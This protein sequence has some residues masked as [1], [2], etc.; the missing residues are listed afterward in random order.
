VAG[1]LDI[2]L[3][4]GVRFP[5]VP[6]IVPVQVMTFLSSGVCSHSCCLRSKRWPLIMLSILF[7]GEISI[8]AVCMF[9]IMDNL[10][11]TPQTYRQ[12]F[13]LSVTCAREI[14]PWIQHCKFELYTRLWT[15]RLTNILDVNRELNDPLFTW[16]ELIENQLTL[17]IFST[18]PLK[19][20]WFLYM[21]KDYR[22]I[23]LLS[24]SHTQSLMDVLL[25]QGIDFQYF[26][27]G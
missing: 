25:Q 27:W 14:L 21:W 7:I 10:H 20:L 9:L 3:A 26:Q 12:A 23:K 6:S 13:L 17:E 15:Y 19:G 11:H 5:D 16:L 1:L 18:L 24:L 2:Q 4:A 8:P 22:T